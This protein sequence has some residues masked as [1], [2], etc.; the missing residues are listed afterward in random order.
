MLII[1]AWDFSHA[2][3]YI[4]CQSMIVYCQVLEVFDIHHLSWKVREKVNQEVK[5]FACV[6]VL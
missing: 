3:A 6:P 5:E 2:T 1:V 4:R